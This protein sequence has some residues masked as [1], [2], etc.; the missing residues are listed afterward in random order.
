MSTSVDSTSVGGAG[1]PPNIEQGQTSTAGN[2]NTNEAEPRI[3][4]ETVENPEENSAKASKI[5]A[6]S[7]IVISSATDLRSIT[8]PPHIRK[9]GHPKGSDL[10]V[11]GVPKKRL[12]LKR[13]PVHFHQLETCEKDKILLK[14]FVDD[15]VAERYINS[16]NKP[17]AE[18]EVECCP[19]RI[20]MA[21]QLKHASIL[22]R[23][24]L[25]QIRGLCCC[26]FLRVLRQ[27]LLQAKFAMKSLKPNAYLVISV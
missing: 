7:D 12:K 1:P 27:G 9:R 22:S 6:D 19:E 14:W 18:E 3:P 25:K 11:I 5:A 17:V 2:T 15:D 26:M 21:L 4:A 24:I 20:N 16:D 23:N 8:L 13:R 10:T